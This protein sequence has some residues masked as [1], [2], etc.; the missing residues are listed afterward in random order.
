MERL[1]YFIHKERIDAEPF[2]FPMLKQFLKGWEN[3]AITL[4]LG[5]SV[6]WDQSL[7]SKN[8]TS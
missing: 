7:R 2:Y 3:T 6:L 8:A 5:T 1:H 4:S